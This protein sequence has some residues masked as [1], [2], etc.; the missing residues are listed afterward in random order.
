MMTLQQMQFQLRKQVFHQTYQLI[1]QKLVQMQNEQVR[2]L[3]EWRQLVRYL[4]QKILQ[5]KE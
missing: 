3:K 1:F 5:I 2:M 4:P